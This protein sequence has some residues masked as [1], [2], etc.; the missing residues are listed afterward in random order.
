[1]SLLFVNNRTV[2][3]LAPKLISLNLNLYFP[4]DCMGI[5]TY[6][7]EANKWTEFG[8]LALCVGSLTAYVCNVY[9]KRNINVLVGSNIY[10]QYLRSKW[11]PWIFDLPPKVGSFEFPTGILNGAFAAPRVWTRFSFILL[12]FRAGFSSGATVFG[13]M[14]VLLFAFTALLDIENDFCD[15][16]FAIFC[17]AHVCT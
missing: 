1:M 15:L 2:N 10:S 8:I 6:S 4:L 5:G 3:A 16:V 14:D 12:P 11:M 13:W 7:V 17:I 9:E